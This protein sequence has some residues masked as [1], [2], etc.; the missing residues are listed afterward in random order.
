MTMQGRNYTSETYRFGYQ[1]SEKETGVSGMYT[2]EYRALDVRLGRW[3]MPDPITQPWQSPYCSMDNNPIA[4]TDVMGLSTGGSTEG[5]RSFESNSALSGY[6]SRSPDCGSG[7]VSGNISFGPF[8]FDL[9]NAAGQGNDKNLPTGTPKGREYSDWYRTTDE[10]I[11]NSAVDIY[12]DGSYAESDWMVFYDEDMYVGNN[13]VGGYFV[14]RRYKITEVVEIPGTPD[15]PEVLATDAKYEWIKE[16]VSRNP[17]YPAGPSV[18][19]PAVDG[20]NDMIYDS[21]DANGN[22]FT[23]AD[24][25]NNLYNILNSTKAANEVLIFSLDVTYSGWYTPFQINHE[26][27]L[28]ESLN[29]SITLTILPDDGSISND[30]PIKSKGKIL[31]EHFKVIRIKYKYKKVKTQDAKPGKPAKKGTQARKEIKSRWNINWEDM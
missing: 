6:M 17:E 7:D 21:K 2:T 11:I 1:G 23:P 25:Y 29:E 20:N 9:P 14:Q 26:T 13:A 10:S 19:L 16:E 5:T 8:G 27:R 15:E 12:K 18:P 31:K 3:F 28:K 22:P 4:L 30:Y 24:M